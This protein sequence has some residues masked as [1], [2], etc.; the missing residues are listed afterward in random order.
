MRAGSGEKFGAEY[1]AEAEE[2]VEQQPVV[3]EDSVTDVDYTAF[4]CGDWGDVRRELHDI[5]SDSRAGDVQIIAPTVAALGESTGEIASRL[6]VLQDVCDELRIR[7][8]GEWVRLSVGSSDYESVLRWWTA[9]GNA[10]VQL[11]RAAE[12]R[13]VRLWS[14]VDKDGGRAG[15]GFEWKEV[16]GETEWVPADNYDRVCALLEMV[17]TGELSKN[18]CAAELDTSP[19]TITRCIEERPER[20][21]LHLV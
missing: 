10:G 3:I 13:D 7:S 6:D 12:K 17:M 5:D 20:Y 8:D 9:A 15:I 19:R 14:G 1:R 4:V 21:G 18:Q 11:Q 16:D 2:I